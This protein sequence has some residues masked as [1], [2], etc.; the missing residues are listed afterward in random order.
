M[1]KAPNKV[2]TTGGAHPLFQRHDVRKCI[3]C[4][5]APTTRE[6]II[7]RWLRKRIPRTT[8]TKW[9]KFRA[10]EHPSKSDF[11][12]GQRGGDPHDWF[13]RCVCS[14]CN[15]EWMSAIER[16]AR[17]I[18]EP[19]VDGSTARVHAH[20]QLILATWCVM[21]NMVAEFD[22]PQRVT[23][24][25]MQRKRMWRRHLPPRWGWRIWI[26]CYDRQDWVPVFVNNTLLI[27]TREILPARPDI[28]VDRYNTQSA[29]YVIGKLLVHILH[30][31]YRPIVRMWTP[32][33]EIS[34]KLR[35]IW[36]HSGYSFPW[37]PPRMGDRDADRIAGA[38]VNFCKE[39]AARHRSKID[40]PKTQ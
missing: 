2:R 11:S 33:S 8:N 18:L 39:S 17:T 34:G 21:K 36:P 7:S 1:S 9:D 28:G 5:S 6:H 40:A 13:V 32:P 26:G 14:K 3:F 23:T 16:Q 20:D 10:T 31:P 25:H 38:F 22:F 24:H 30:S 37:P 15:N 12:I 35:L 4:G 27:E 19:L 29:T